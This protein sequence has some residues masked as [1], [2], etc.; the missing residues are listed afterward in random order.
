MAFSNRSFQWESSTRLQ[1][2]A[3]SVTGLTSRKMAIQKIQAP[4]V[5]GGA[6]GYGTRIS[7]STN[8]GQGFGGNFQ[9]SITGNDV[10]LTGN[11]KS[12][13][14]NL[15]DR[16]ASYLEK[17]R[18]LEKANSAIEKQIK[19]WYET[20]NT[21]VRRDYSSYFKT[22]EDL[23]NKIAAA[24]LENAK[25]ALQ[26]DNAKLAAADFRLKY[27]NE[28]LLRQNV[29]S[30][31][32]GL[33]RVHDDLT[34]SKSD[35]ESQIE[36]VNEELAFLKKNHEEDID[37]LHKQVSSSANTEV[38]AAPNVDLATTMENVRQQ[39][40]EMAEKNCQEAKEQFEKQTEELNQEIALYVEQLEAQRREITDR[41][42]IIQGLELEL[43]SQ[44]NMRKALEDTLHRTEARYGYQL[45]QIQAEVANLEA[46]LRQL[47]DDMEAQSSEYN[48]LLDIKTRLETEIAT[49]HRLLEGEDSGHS[50]VDVPT[51]QL[52]K[53][54]SKIKKIKTIVEEV[55]NGKVVSSQ[56]KE[57]ALS[58]MALSVRTSGGSRQFS[59]RSGLGGG[60][61]RMSS[62][63]SGGGFGGSG[64]G[65]GGGSGGRFG[66]ASMLG[67][68]S[69]FSGGFGSS[70]SSGFGG[71][72]GSGLGGSYGS[73]L[74]SAFGGG[75]GSGFG[76][77]SGTGFGGGFGSDSGPGFGGGFGT[78]GAGD[79][80]LLSGSKKETMQNLNDRL[81][82][83][84]DKVRALEDANT[85]LEHKIREWYEK[86]GPGAGI[87]GSGNDYSKYY[88]IIEDLRNKIINATIDNA[89]IILQVDNARLAADDFRLKYE[90]EVALRQSVEA[91][92]NGLR[93]VLD[94]LTLTRADLEMQIESLNEELAYLKKNHEE[95]LQGIQSSTFGQ[96]S[97]E[98][99][100]A[101]GTDLTKLLNDMRG[102]YE[103]IAEQNRKEAEAW[104]NEKSGELKREIST[105]A[106]QLQS[107][108][109]EI[110]D[111]KRT[112]QSLEIELQSQLAM[113]KSLE[114]TLAETEGG[115][116]AQLSQM[117][118]QIGNLE[119]QLFQVRADTERQNAE[120]QQLLDIKTRLEMEIETYR[121][122]LDGEFVSAG[123][124]VTLE[125]SSLTGSKSQTQSLD[126]SQDPTKTRKIKTIV[127]EV[128]DGKVV[129]SHVK[130][131]EEKI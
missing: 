93:R 102:Q 44:H 106:E 112:F 79:G 126:S 35:L 39:Y 60:S 73:G 47:R 82:A 15:N 86:N 92:I 109:S 125:S 45:T 115:Y 4:S 70:L 40:E 111:L 2:T 118:L 94:E 22:I 24:Q 113:K 55:V 27:E 32:N 63:S 84:L 58:T 12:T 100:A 121:R 74:G 105:N 20:N 9:L 110:T 64:F 128:V 34:L 87:P 78:A 7:T 59:S 66:A 81:A 1:P 46:Q 116:C 42:P 95:E 71:G 52:E 114:D 65:F 130:E 5:Y 131:V 91:D 17:V 97:V 13:M 51:A 8:Y 80:G 54:T 124:G 50:Q 67:S 41:R 43:Q 26:T 120:Y 29:E 36:S 10:L 18:S 72:F 101:P 56:T 38:D 25:L 119:S 21:V 49:Y 31:I 14:Q 62:S 122:L 75:L 69:G 33:L 117:Q 99:D 85:E 77:S 28:Q 107:G 123:Q 19:E 37:R 108:K 16:L 57:G 127:E 3:P 76:S 96:V 53:E 11:E 104:F 23:Q 129:A 68:G 90:N 83:Y 30:D 6:G 89:R 98:M 48:V 61:L 88:P 103:A